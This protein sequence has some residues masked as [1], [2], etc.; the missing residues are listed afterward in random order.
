V[1]LAFARLAIAAKIDSDE[2]RALAPWNDLTNFA[3]HRDSSLARNRAHL[4]HTAFQQQIELSVVCEA[5][6]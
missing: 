5:D 6:D 4:Q 1:V 3:G 2:P